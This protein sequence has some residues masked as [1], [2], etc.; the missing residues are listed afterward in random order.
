MPVTRKSRSRKKRKGNRGTTTNPAPSQHAS[1]IQGAV[2][3]V[4]GSFTYTTAARQATNLTQPF[5]THTVPKATTTEVT[6]LHF[7]GHV[8][9][10]VETTLRA[11]QADAIVREVREATE[12]VVSRPIHIIAGWWSIGP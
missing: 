10:Q 9:Q 8:D 7:R 2:N 5:T 6:V 12:K 1:G 11:H 4:P 3:L